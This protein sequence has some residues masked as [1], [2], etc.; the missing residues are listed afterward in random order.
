MKLFAFLAVAEA[1]VWIH[2]QVRAANKALGIPMEELPGVCFFQCTGDLA[3]EEI[4]CG[5][6]ELDSPEYEQCM[7]D[8]EANFMQCIS[9]DGC[10]QADGTCAERCIPIA[11]SDFLKCETDYENGLLTELEFVKCIT[12]AEVN[13][14]LIFIYS[15][16][17][18]NL[19]KQF[20]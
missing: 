6:H 8:A 13:F 1:S 18:G 11:E 20:Q 16:E 17:L 12:K 9:V 15:A 19:S 5:K 7:I 4:R 10:I 3:R 14:I 2:P